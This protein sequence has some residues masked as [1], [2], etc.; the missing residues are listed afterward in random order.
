ME[1]VTLLATNAWSIT[2]ELAPWLLVGTALAGV[3]HV[4]LP[5]GFVERQLAGR[6]GVLK[7][8]VLGIPL[9]LCSCSV[10]PTGIGLRAD[11]ASRGATVGFLIATPQTGVDS[12]AVSAGLLGW[13]FA[14]AKVG[15]ALITG[16]VGGLVTE[17]LPEAPE[18]IEPSRDHADRTWRGGVAHGVD[19]VRMIWRW[20]VFGVLLSA[21]LTT[22]VPPS[23][24]DSLAGEGLIAGFVVALLVSL[25]L[26]VCATASVP[27]AAAL[28]HAGLP[29]GAAMVFLMAGPATNLAT[30]GAVR[31][32]FGSAVTAAYVGTLVAG[33][34]LFGLLYEVLVGEVT[35]TLGADHVHTSPVAVAG[36]VV[37]LAMIAWFAIEDL[38][39]ALRPAPSAQSIEIPVEGMTC[40][41]CAS[42]LERVL[43]S[44]EGV[45][46]AQVSLDERLA[47]I[48]GALPLAQL[49]SVITSAGFEPGS[50]R[51]R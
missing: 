18:Q 17:L 25:P 16:L 46:S 3:L 20:L 31:K 30:L 23:A 1:L 11:G 22:F 42:R 26:Y 6:W 33:S 2:L 21:A 50:P 48:D 9:P 37:L 7:A 45:A 27:I 14:I 39:S 13:P 49:A 35:V 44:T 19:L 29:T 15:A 51:T 43:L 34:V 40:K 32:A 24:F 41:G 36:A 47:R 28:I 4:V 8:V 5:A 38:R 10:I 12:I